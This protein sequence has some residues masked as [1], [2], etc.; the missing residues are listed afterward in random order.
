[1]K[2]LVVDDE[3]VAL[4]SIRRLLKRRNLRD[5]KICDNGPEAIELIK[6]QDFDVVLLDLLMPDIDGLEVLE[7]TKPFRPDVEFVILT[8]VDDV[9]SAVKAIRLGAFDYLVKPVDNDRLLITIE[10]AYERR[11][12]RAGLAG[13]YKRTGT[14]KIPEAFS[15]IITHNPRMIELLTYAQIMARG[16]NPVLITGESGTGKELM[17]QGI[18]RAGPAAQGPFVAVNVS[19]IPESLFESQ[20]FG[21]IKGAFTGAVAEYKGFFEQADGGTLFLDEIGELPLSLQSKLLRV[22][23]EQTLSRIGSTKLIPVN[24]RIISATNIDIDNALKE[25]KFRLDLMCRLKSAHIHLPP[26]NER[27]DDI[28]LLAN[29]FLK[30]AC[31]RYGKAIHG[32]SP[33][34]AELLLHKKW[35]G[36]IRSL[37]Q[38]VANAV[39]LADTDRIEPGHLGSPLPAIPLNK[40]TLCSLKEDHC[41]HLAYILKHTQGDCKKAA[42][43]L[44]VSVRQVQRLISQIK[45]DPSFRALLSD[46]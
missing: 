9:A 11:G 36:N 42:E 22:I 44:G 16:N 18:H 13:S 8:A 19:A 6:A 32:F 38:E 34:A 35:P 31:R 24:V 12:L 25:G 10:R 15:N 21:H 3:T 5:V 26:L 29:H 39:L 1:M 45:Q 2:I 28:P 23:E 43:I 30:Q 33:A 17:A 37:A 20:I 27:E 46:I 4:T 41:R 40:R 14:F 7:T